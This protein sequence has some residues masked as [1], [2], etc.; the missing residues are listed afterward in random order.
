LGPRRAH[1]RLA[2]PVRGVHQQAVLRRLAQ[3]LR[4]RLGVRGG[5]AAAAEAEG[6]RPA[7]RRPL[8]ALLAAALLAPACGNNNVTIPDVT[9][10]V[11]NVTVDPNPIPGT[12]NELTLAVSATYTITVTETAGLGG[13][14]A[15]VSA[16]VYE[17]STGRLV[18]LNYYDAADLVV[19]HGGKR[20]EPLGT[21]VLPQTTSYTLSDYTKPANLV[22]S[23]QLKD[24]RT[25]LI[26]TSL[27]VKIE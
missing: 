24:D 6:V 7:P 13:E 12:Q 3:P 15:F 16:A 1:G 20:L 5:R 21:L 19:Y 26:N 17:P 9:R 11:L 2:V 4:L 25:N 8:A 18:A 27:L 10:A 14:L 22:V 23:V